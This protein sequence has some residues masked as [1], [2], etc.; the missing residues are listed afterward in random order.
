MM[1]PFSRSP[2][3]RSKPNAN[4]SSE[5]AGTPLTVFLHKR[6]E[7]AGGG[8]VSKLEKTDAYANNFHRPQFD[9]L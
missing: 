7:Q 1:Y 6:L 9:R 3:R 5:Q 4:W 8:S 2:S